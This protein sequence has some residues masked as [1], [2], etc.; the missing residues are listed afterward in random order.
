MGWAD[1]QL[2]PPPD[3]MP[4]TSAV[5]LTDCFQS[6]TMF[7]KVLKD[8]LNLSRFHFACKYVFPSVAIF[9]TW[10]CLGN[11]YQTRLGK[12]QLVQ[13]NGQVRSINVVFEQ[14]TKSSYK[15]YPLII[16]LTNSTTNFRIRDKFDDWFPYLEYEIHIGDT[17]QIYTRTKFQTL[18]GWGKNGDV[19]LI[20]KGDKLLFPTN[21]MRDYNAGQ[22]TGL[23]FLA[24]LFWAPFLLYKLKVIN[25]K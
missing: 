15:Y 18:L 19:Y 6:M 21:V 17:I 1:G 14:G 8:L 10:G 13:Y 4:R 23:L 5:T 12:S 7:K 11:F 24:L 20:E 9:L 22:A 16:S 3:G 2:I 25:P